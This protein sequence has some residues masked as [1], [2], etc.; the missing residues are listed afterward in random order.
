MHVGGYVFIFVS[1]LLSWHVQADDLSKCVLK[2]AQK[3]HRLDRED[4]FRR[5]FDENKNKVS[6]DQCLTHAKRYK[7]LF[8]SSQ[9]YQENLGICFYESNS[10][11]NISDCIKTAKIFEGANDHDEAVFFCYQTFQE[12]LSKNQCLA[13]AKTMRFPWKE[14]YLRNH[15]LNN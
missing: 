12:K 2:V 11:N 14:Q 7:T 15:C 1:L 8:S 9:L 4:G 10:F 3:E 13:V 5:C 6:K